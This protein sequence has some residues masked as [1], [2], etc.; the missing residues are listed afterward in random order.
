MNFLEQ[1]AGEWYEYQ[2]YFVRRNVLVGRRSQGGYECELDVVAF[3]PSNRHIVH[4]EP[5]MDAHSWKK[6]EIRYKKKFSAGRNYIPNLFKDFKISKKDDIEQITLLGFAGKGKHKTLAGG[7]ILL[8]QDFFPEIMS[9]LKNTRV[10]SNAI[11]E[12]LPLLRTLQFVADNRG[13][14][15]EELSKP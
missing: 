7:R 15:F 13:P 11:P 8:I 9:K 5:S 14:V 6:R 2:G 4:V 1:L 10:R 12:S 3:N